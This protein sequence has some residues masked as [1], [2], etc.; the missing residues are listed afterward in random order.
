MSCRFYDWLSRK[1]GIWEEKFKELDPA[2]QE[3]LIMEFA[4]IVASYGGRM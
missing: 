4:E 1:Y 2:V 3:N